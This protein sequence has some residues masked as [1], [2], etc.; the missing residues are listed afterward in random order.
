MQICITGGSY[1]LGEA[2]A[3][4][5]EALGHSV[6]VIDK[7]R[8][9]G[10][11]CAYIHH[12]F[13]NK[14]E[15][16]VA[17]DLLI[18]NHATFDGFS[19]FSSMSSSYVEEYLQINLFSH[20]EVLLKF[21]YAKAVFINSVLSITS[22]PNVSLYSASKSFMKRFLET[23]QREGA[24][25]LIV[26]P[27]KINTSLFGSVKDFYTLD[28]Y[29][30]AKEVYRAVESGKKTLYLPRIFRLSYFFALFPEAVQDWIIAL[31]YRLLVRKGKSVDS[32][33]YKSD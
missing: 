24:H 30:V 15:K 2:L 14:I 1:G 20:I 32:S 22:F 3:R 17:C 18:I 5:G 26:Y 7:K 29:D 4:T 12:D 9:P 16:A 10:L 6:T 21:R 28:R 19:S 13:K 27:F 8:N 25:V 11:K 23:I 31:V 33:G